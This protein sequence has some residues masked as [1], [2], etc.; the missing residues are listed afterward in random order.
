MPGQNI[1]NIVGKFTR[2]RSTNSRLDAVS[3]MPRNRRSI[4]VRLIWKLVMR[5]DNNSH[6]PGI[7]ELSNTST[8]FAKT[9]RD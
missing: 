6:N 4:V 9:V 3:V 1:D 5:R 8:P 7:A 2:Y